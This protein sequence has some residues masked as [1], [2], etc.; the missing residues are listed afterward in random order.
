[1]MRHVHLCNSDLE[2]AAQALSMLANRYRR[3]AERQADPAAR[4]RFEKHAADCGRV[5][6]QMT[7][8]QKSA[9]V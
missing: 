4:Q 7:R 5:A 8:F 6:K 1:M 2:L 3:D 9:T